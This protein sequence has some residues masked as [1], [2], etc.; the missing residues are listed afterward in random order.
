[1]ATGPG[2]ADQC[3]THAAYGPSYGKKGRQDDRDQVEGQ[4]TLADV[5]VL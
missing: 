1:M 2:P 4:I 3:I 5:R